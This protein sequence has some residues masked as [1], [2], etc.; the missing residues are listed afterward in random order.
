M[1]VFLAILIGV[2]A[3]KASRFMTRLTPHGKW[4]KALPVLSAG[5]VML[6]GIS[7]AFTSLLSGGVVSASF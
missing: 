7:L 1:A 2:M 5:I 6:V 4:V 3:A